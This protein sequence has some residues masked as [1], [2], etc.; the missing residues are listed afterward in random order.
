[1]SH[2]DK[3][4]TLVFTMPHRLKP[5]D[6]EME[7][8]IFPNCSLIA[9][10]FA[11]GLPFFSSPSFRSKLW[12]TSRT[13]KSRPRVLSPNLMKV[14]NGRTKKSQG[15]SYIQQKVGSPVLHLPIVVELMLGIKFASFVINC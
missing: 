12:H 8:T 7:L 15:Q 13:L 1:M 9:F 10:D 4:C 5:G 14:S 2:P 6:T 11:M 3:E